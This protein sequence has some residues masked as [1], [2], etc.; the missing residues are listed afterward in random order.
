MGLTD[1]GLA[2]T[3]ET[4]TRIARALES[5]A[6]RMD[7]PAQELVTKAAT[8]E[9]LVGD[10]ISIM[11]NPHSTDDEWKELLSDAREALGKTP[12]DNETH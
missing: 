3:E 7:D 6:E 9:S 5:I 11:E 2:V 4:A 8:L 12:Q 10:F 1:V